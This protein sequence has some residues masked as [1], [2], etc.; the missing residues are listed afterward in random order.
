MKLLEKTKG[1]WSKIYP[2]FGIKYQVG[3]KHTECPLC[4]KKKFRITD[5][6][7]LGDW[8]CT[9]GAGQGI[10]LIL[11]KTGQD[12][13]SVAR[14]IEKIIG[15]QDDYSERLTPKI[16]Q[17]Q[18][19]AVNGFRRA[20]LLKG[21]EGETYLNN[22]GL[23]LLPRGGV[24]FGVAQDMEYKRSFNCL[25]ALASNEWGEAIYRHVTYIE[26]GLK[27][28]VEKQK[29]MLAL[30]EYSGSIAIKLFHHQ[31]T[32]CIAEGIETAIAATQ[33]FKAPTWATLNATLMKR[34]KAPPGVN[35]LIIYADN[36]RG[37]TGLAAAFEC[38]RANVYANNDVNRVTVK[39]TQN[40]G[41]FADYILE[42]TPINEMPLYK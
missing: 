10:K 20:K 7:G 1:H 32:L 38:G 19:S 16:N 2:H 12:F 9:C 27:A 29:K 23:Y 8:I 36:D 42:P 21:T 22:R 4:N 31:T 26:N 24:K 11:E 41:D 15:V 25:Y 3:N 40:R 6:M 33:A 39:W 34:F 14:E 13:A 28:Q 37:G 18:Q 17:K 35:H 30:Q 5:R